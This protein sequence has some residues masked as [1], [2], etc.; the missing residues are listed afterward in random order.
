MLYHSYLLR[1]K[2]QG[3]KHLLHI[4]DLTNTVFSQKDN[5]RILSKIYLITTI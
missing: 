4:Y 1:N 3:S 2:R 5:M